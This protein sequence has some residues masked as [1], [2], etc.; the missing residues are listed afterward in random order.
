MQVKQSRARAA[1][2]SYKQVI[3][4]SAAREKILRGEAQP[5][6]AVRVMLAPRSKSVLIQKKWGA[7]IVCNDGVTIAEEIELK[8]AEANLGAHNATTS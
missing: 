6:D 7:P 4:R 2:P 8:D 3:F 5:A 1:L